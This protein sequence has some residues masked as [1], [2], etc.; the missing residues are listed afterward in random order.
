MAAAASQALLFSATLPKQLMQFARAGL[1]DPELIRLDVERKI[2][3]NLKVRRGK[4]A[5]AV[6]PPRCASCTF[7]QPALR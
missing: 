7:P 6:G 3:E 4:R 1:R 5:P 2:S